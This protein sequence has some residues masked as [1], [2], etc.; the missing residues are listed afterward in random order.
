ML[1][2]ILENL[3]FI[4]EKNWLSDHSINSITRITCTIENARK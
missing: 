3:T 4:D 2:D 1:S